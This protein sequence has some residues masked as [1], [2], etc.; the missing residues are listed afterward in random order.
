MSTPIGTLTPLCDSPWEGIVFNIV[1]FIGTSLGVAGVPACL[2]FIFEGYQKYQTGSCNSPASSGRLPWL[3]LE[4]HVFF[5]GWLAMNIVFGAAGW[6]IW[7]FQGRVCDAYVTLGLWLL[8]MFIAA[9]WPLAMFVAN[10]FLLSAI[11]FGLASLSCAAMIITLI[12][13]SF[14]VIALLLLL[15]FGAWLVF[16]LVWTTWAWYNADFRFPSPR[17][18]ASGV[19]RT[20]GPGGSVPDVES[21]TNYSGGDPFVGDAI[22]LKAV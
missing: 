1:L 15:V 21:G 6:V 8:T 11:V 7:Y 16:N 13:F 9:M 5:A 22:D 12:L 10:S 20:L 3:A 4:R 17:E 18:I 19:L 2:G 14:D